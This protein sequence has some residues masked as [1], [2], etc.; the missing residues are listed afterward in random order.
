LS[1]NVKVGDNVKIEDMSIIGDNTTIEHNNIL[2][3]GIKINVNSL[4]TEE[5][6]TF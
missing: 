5:Q 4:I 2:K 6:I 3:N 1:K